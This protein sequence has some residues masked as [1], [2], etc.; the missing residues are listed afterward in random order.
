M[1][2][3]FPCALLLSLFG[4]TQMPAGAQSMSI[5]VTE[6]DSIPGVGLVI[7]VNAVSVSS[8][9]G[10]FVEVDTDNPD[11]DANGVLLQNSNV[12][13][14]EGQSL[15][16]PGG[17]TLDNFDGVSIAPDGTL[18]LNLFLDGTTPPANDSGV[19]VGTNL[20]IQEGDVS[21]AAAFAPGTTYEGFF[22]VQWGSNGTFLVMASVDDPS[23]PTTVDRA[24][25]QVTVDAAG[26]LLSEE[27]VWKEGDVPPGQ[28]QPIAN[29]ETDT[30]EYAINGQGVTMV[31]VD[32]AG[33]TTV[34]HA[35]YMGDTLL[36][37]EGSPS[38]VAGRNWGTLTGVELDLNDAGDWI[39]KANLDSSDNTTDQVLV[40]NGAIYRR[41]GDSLPDIAPFT[42]QDFGGANG[43]FMLPNGDVLWFGDWD[44]PDLTR[45]EGLFLNDQLIL[46]EGVTVVGGNTIIDLADFSETL[47]VSED[48]RFAVI[49]GEINPMGTD[50]DVA[51][52]IELGLG[53]SYC[54]SNPNSTGLAAALS[55]TGSSSIAAND[56]TLSM[57]QLPP[58]SFAFF[59][60]SQTQGFVAFPGGSD[61]NLCVVGSIGRYVGP[62]QIQQ[63]SAAG[64]A[65][66]AIDLTQIPQP[67]GFVSAQ[68]GEQWNFQGWHRDL[69][70]TGATSNFSDG[71]TI[72][73]TP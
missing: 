46:Q 10:P 57:S 34:D 58:L 32:L 62:G 11:T 68:A 27:V 41:E 1:K 30:E 24:L 49:E 37:Q 52:L 54:D 73:F 2:I 67:N 16:V 40:R 43:V 56:M 13:L 20:L 42:F 66:L 15:N 4:A 9:E 14:R 38:P 5:L 65:N 61:G 21:T 35:I 72:V 51:I 60:V 64:T 53:T 71:V 36:M 22:D 23:I 63:S 8:V 55:I 17:A 28:T 3:T 7:R 29:L 47:D 50:L 69:T 44:D 12:L 26:N 31:T 45:D 6:G 33:D 59:L 48:G 25:V 39:A 70:S 19:F 18:A